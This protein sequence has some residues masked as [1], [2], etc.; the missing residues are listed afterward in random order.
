M[1]N[2]AELLTQIARFQIEISSAIKEFQKY[3][4]DCERDLYILTK[5]DLLRVFKKYLSNSITEKEINEWANF[6]EC[7]EDLGYENESGELLKQIIID[8]ANPDLSE[9]ISKK[10]I[11]N[12]EKKLTTI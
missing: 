9:P 6:L 7:R 5:S 10:L 11:T 12:Y 8:L 4:W 3:S 1:K 2:R